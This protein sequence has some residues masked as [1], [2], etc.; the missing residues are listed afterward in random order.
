M[1]RSSLKKFLGTS[2][3]L[4]FFVMPAASAHAA[5]ASST[6]FTMTDSSFGSG[7]QMDS[8]S[9]SVTGTLS[10]SQNVSYASGLLPLVPGTITSCGK[11]T[12]PGTYSLNSSFSNISGPCF[13][14][15]TSG[16]TINGG[17]HSVTGVSGNSA[18]AVTATSSVSNGGSAFE[19]LAIQDIV[20]VNFA[21]GVNA[22]G[23]SGTVSGGRGGSVTVAS[24]T[25]GSIVVNGGAAGSG[26]G[27]AGGSISISGDNLDLVANPLSANGGSGSSSGAQ[28]NIL[29]SGSVLI[30]GTE[31]WN[32]DDS[33]WSGSRTWRF[34]D[35][36]YNNGPVSGTTT[37]SA[38]TATSSVVIIDANANFHGTG[39]ANG[40]VLDSLGEPIVTWNLVHGS[41]LT[42]VVTGG[43]SS[44]DVIFDDA[45]SNAGTVIGDA[46]FNGSSHNAGTVSS[47]STFSDFSYNAG[48]TTNAVFTA[49]SFNSIAGIPNGDPTGISNGHVISGT[50]TF[51]ATSSPVNFNVGSG[52][53]WGANTSSWI[54]AT[55][56]QNWTFNLGNNAGIIFGD[57]LF[58]NAHNSGQVSG[59]T[60]FQSGSYN[61]GTTATSSFYD[62]S[63]NIGLSTY[64]NFYDSSVNSHGSSPGTV[65]VR[66]DF[67]NSSLPGIGSCPVGGTFYHIPY[68]FNNSVS[69]NWDDLGNWWFDPSFTQPAAALPQG[70]DTVYI[71]A[72]LASGPS[73]P[74]SLGSIFVASSTTGGGSFSAN[75]TNA[76][77]P[78][79]FYALSTNAGE[80]NGIFHIFGNRGLSQVNVGGTFTGSVAFH[81]S[82]WN[83]VS[84]AGNASFYD[85]SLN[86][87][88]GVVGGSA[89]FRGT[90]RNEGTVAGVATVYSGA[91]L[92][93]AGVIQGNTLN[94]GTITDGTFGSAVT[95]V[96]GVITGFITNAVKM[97]FNGGGYV[98]LG[99]VVSGAS[100]FN[101]TSSNR[102]IVLGNSTFNDSSYNTGTTSSATFV[103]DLSE[104][105]Y[106][107]LVGFVSG[108]KTRLYS[109]VAPQLTMLRD[110]SD[111]AWTI[112][113][114]NTVVK[115]VYRNLVNLFGQNPGAETTLVERNGGF[116]LRPLLPGVIN[117][118][119]VLDTANGVY[120]LGSDISSYAYDT[121][122]IVRANGVVID[123]GDHSVTGL[124]TS[125][126]LYS[127][128]STSTL[129]IDGTS[130]AFTDLTIRNVRFSNFAHGLMGRGTDVPSGVG[131]K[132]TSVTVDHSTIGNIDVSGGDPT[133]RA[134]DGGDV[135]VITSVVAVIASNGGDSTACGIAGNGGSVSITTDSV[136]D[137]IV[138][139]G[140]IVRGCP[141]E[142]TP[143]H[144]TRGHRNT[145]VISPATKASQAALVPKAT[146]TSNIFTKIQ[147]LG[148]K[149]IFTV[150]LPV[151]RLS[152][153]SLAQ[154]PS[155]GDGGKRAFSF[156][157]GVTNFLFA[158]L[159]QGLGETG[160]R[161]LAS[162]GIRYERELVGLQRKPLAIKGA[163]GTT[164]LFLVSSSGAAVQSYLTYD[165]KTLV[166]QSI[167]ADPGSRLSL[168]LNSG[169]DAVGY[170]NGKR[171][172]FVGGKA[173][174]VV[175]ST[176]GKFILTTTSSSLPL[177]INVVGRSAEI[178]TTTEIE[179]SVGENIFKAVIK[180]AIGWLSSLFR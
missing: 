108:I 122:F 97:V 119:G 156:I 106:N 90:N 165:P 58:N 41:I 110:F 109:A 74:I 10:Q 53:S 146:A 16:V 49:T 131:G 9:F 162:L 178:G 114:D 30:T 118:C 101:A 117:S 14:V 160:S 64:A 177:I 77:G 29:M 34:D 163:K 157:S 91:M 75:L 94:L 65:S 126:S 61:A 144:G 35:A 121:C 142:V 167:K 176:S 179:G 63:Y 153:I 140:G 54:F 135:S 92:T 66:C 72:H 161:V 19:G 38:Y 69:S 32:G 88:T 149:N 112:I 27:G 123:G 33:L 31:V 84:L 24:S 44:P 46:A 104:N 23:N 173:T 107:G 83:D 129:S 4:G 60:V 150:I 143:I 17:G 42:G 20:F 111:S 86:S 93:N 21:G 67:F 174:I 52:A 57:A 155:F 166:A 50:I 2:L 36:S 43:L 13:V 168:Y 137:S 48:T 151:A 28:G 73:S 124:S 87:S 7:R 5:Q 105:A 102:G 37:L 26:A 132:G 127:V 152:P 1:K 170:L 76:S 55:A 145:A 169:E 12:V 59:T 180:K 47:S 134:G 79:Y 113:A 130:D 70:G 99:G 8:A 95:N 18:Y 147:A 81:D 25:I 133:E 103:G 3:V 6:N 128:V 115:L 80:V 85:T 82:S 96:A 22:S 148:L 56:G 138:N 62:A 100:E 98:S 68:Y 116:I 141:Q 125:T 40:T 158:P 175:P 139:E 15:A 39:R 164:G 159:P 45:S 51:S 154:L 120:T 171:V 71:G 89:D 11:I 78:A 172:S 136:Y